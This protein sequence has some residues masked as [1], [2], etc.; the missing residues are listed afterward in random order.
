MS[1]FL[2]TII[3]FATATGLALSPA[4]QH[5]LSAHPTLTTLLGLASWL[6]AHWTPSP[7]QS[8]Q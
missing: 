4:M 7:N 3:A 2:P 1:K 5:L 8:G 6:I